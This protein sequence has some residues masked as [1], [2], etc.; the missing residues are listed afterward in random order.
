MHSGY[1]FQSNIL[2]DGRVAYYGQR[3][4]SLSKCALDPYSRRHSEVLPICGY[5]LLSLCMQSRRTLAV[6]CYP[7]RGL[8]VDAKRT[9][10]YYYRCIESIAAYGTISQFPDIEW[11][12]S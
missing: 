8:L 9:V 3:M 4:S 10:A 12:S 5:P 6:S 7:G 2:K 11:S 1:G